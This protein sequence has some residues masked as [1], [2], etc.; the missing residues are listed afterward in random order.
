MAASGST[1]EIA[2]LQIEIPAWLRKVCF[3][4]CAVNL[5]LCLVAYFV[6]AWIY[7]PN[8]LGIPTDFISFW[9]AGRLVLNGSGTGL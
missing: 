7:D 9:A 8:G 5:T 1:L 3:A 4:L 2:Q 6:H